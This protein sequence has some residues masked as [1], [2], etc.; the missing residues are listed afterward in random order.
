M[1]PVMPDD[2]AQQ[3]GDCRVGCRTAGLNGNQYTKVATTS[4]GAADAV[5]DVAAIEAAASANA[6][7]AVIAAA[8]AATA[9]RQQHNSCKANVQ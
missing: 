6:T 9:P 5:E 4:S 8:T 2:D 3:Q 1:G 7:T